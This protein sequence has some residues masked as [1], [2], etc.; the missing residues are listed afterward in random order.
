MDKQMKEEKIGLFG[1]SL[2]DDYGRNLE[3]FGER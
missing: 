2:L 1:V 3:W